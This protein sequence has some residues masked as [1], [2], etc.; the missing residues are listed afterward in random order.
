[1]IIIKKKSEKNKYIYMGT[2][3]T[4]KY[5]HIQ[6]CRRSKEKV[7]DYRGKSAVDREVIVTKNDK[8][9]FILVGL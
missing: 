5:R 2:N 3:R 6:Q 4:I 7:I 1:M 9:R 8:T